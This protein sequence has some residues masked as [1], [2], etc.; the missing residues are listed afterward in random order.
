MINKKQIILS[1]LL[2]AIPAQAIQASP[3]E[4]LITAAG[5]IATGIATYCYFRQNPDFYAMAILG[6]PLVA[7]GNYI[8]V[9]AFAELSDQ[10]LIKSACTLALRAEAQYESIVAYHQQLT[11]SNQII[12]ADLL[13]MINLVNEP[14]DAYLCTM[15]K[16]IRALHDQ[17]KSLGLRIAQGFNDDHDQEVFKQI[18]CDVSTM[19]SMLK[20]VYG[21]LKANKEFFIAAA[22]YEQDECLPQTEQSQQ[23]NDQT[24]QQEEDEYLDEERSPFPVFV[25]VVTNHQFQKQEAA[26]VV[27]NEQA[28]DRILESYRKDFLFG[29]F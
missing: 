2:L 18:L 25:P 4:K 12:D 24:N 9:G 3:Y 15:K 13:P 6:I 19:I 17:K 5:T 20:Q 1:G 16:T 21:F 29:E 27:P 22:V 14:I 7:V 11:Q 8:A 26:S 23:S 10:S 28:H